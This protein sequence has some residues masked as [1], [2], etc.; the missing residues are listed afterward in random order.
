MEGLDTVLALSVF[1]KWNS[2]SP[3]LFTAKEERRICVK[4]GI[5]LK[6]LDLLKQVLHYLCRS[7][8]TFVFCF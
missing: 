2:N 6:A 8:S 5:E 1:K 7:A 3:G 4:C